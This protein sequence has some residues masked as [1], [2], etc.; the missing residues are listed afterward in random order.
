[1]LHKIILPLHAV[2]PWLKILI[3]NPLHGCFRYCLPI[4]ELTQQGWWVYRMDHCAGAYP[5]LDG[6]VAVTE[7]KEV[8]PGCSRLRVRHGLP[9]SGA[10][11]AR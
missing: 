9:L 3:E 10:H 2:V 4:Q 7:D 6:E 5:P 1:M 11:L 8:A